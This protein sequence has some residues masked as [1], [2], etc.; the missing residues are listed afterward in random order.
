MK[1]SKVKHTKF[2]VGI[3]GNAD[4]TK[5]FIY[6][7]PFESKN[8]GLTL[9]KR[10]ENLNK[11]AKNLY[12]IL[13]PHITYTEDKNVI[14]T[15]KD[16][17]HSIN[18]LITFLL[19]IYD[20]KSD[21]RIQLQKK[22]LTSLTPD[23]VLITK[24]N[25]KKNGYEDITM[26]QLYVD[27]HSYGNGQNGKEAV[28]NDLVENCLRK[29]LRKDISIEPGKDPVSI[30]ETVKKIINAATCPNNFQEKLKNTVTD[31]ELTAFF[32]IINKDYDK[33]KRIEQISESIEWQNVKVQ[34][35]LTEYG[36]V[37][38]LSSALEKNTERQKE[39]YKKYIF[40]FITDYTKSDT[41]RKK[42][43]IVHMRQLILLFCTVFYAEDG[44]PDFEKN[45][46]TLDYVK[47][48]KRFETFTEN[49]PEYFCKEAH[50]AMDEISAIK[51]SS[52]KPDGNVYTE[53]K[54]RKKKLQNQV[55][56]SIRT[57]IRCNYSACKILT[58]EH[59]FFDHTQYQPE[60]D[61]CWLNYISSTV[62]K[63][64]VKNR[65]WKY[66]SV[67]LLCRTVFDEWTAYIA[68]KYIHIGKAVYHFA[69]PDLTQ[70]ASQKDVK[71]GEIQ[72]P[73]SEG[74]TSFDYEWI[75]AKETLE[76]DQIVSVTFAVQNY[77]RCICDSRK[78]KD[79][80]EN[81]ED[82][83]LFREEDFKNVLK[84]EHEKQE[85][86]RKM[87]QYF[88]GISKWSNE[89]DGKYSKDNGSFA[90]DFAQAVKNEMF[91][92]RNSCYHYTAII[93]E[94]A[95]KESLMQKM[96][97]IEYRKLGEFLFEKYYSNNVFAFYRTAEI[98]CMMEYLYDRKSSTPSQVPAFNRII[99]GKQEDKD[100][101]VWIS[102]CIGSESWKDGFSDLETRKVYKASFRFLLKE[103]Y[104]HGFLN[105]PGIKKKFLKEIDKR[106]KNGKNWKEEKAAKNLQQRLFSLEKGSKKLSFG[107]I[108]QAIM[109]DYNMQNQGHMK[110]KVKAGPD[111]EN[112][113]DQEIFQHFRMLLYAGI[114]S[115]FSDYLMDKENPGTFGFLKHPKARSME[116]KKSVFDRFTGNGENP[117]NPTL[118]SDVYDA[119]S[120]ETDCQNQ[121]GPELLAWYTTAH[122]MN[123]KQLNLLAGSIKNYIQFSCDIQK[124]EKSA[125]IKNPRIYDTK[126][127]NRYKKVIRVLEF[128]RLFVGQT[129][130]ILEDYFENN[131]DYARHVANYVQLD[132]PTVE[133]LQAFCEQKWR[134]ENTSGNQDDRIGIYFD[135]V[136]P[137]IN[138]NIVYA[139]MYGMEQILKN[140]VEPVEKEEILKLY[141]LRESLQNVF[142]NGK[143]ETKKEQ[144]QLRDFTNC[145]NRI[146][147]V[148]I[149][150]YS[151]M[152]NELF[153]QLVSWA[154]L[155]ERDLMYFQLGYH[156][157]RLF[158]GKK[159]PA[160]D[161]MRTLKGKR[162]DI[163][164]GAILY[165]I[166]AMY[167][168]I[169]PVYKI[170]KE[171]AVIG[172]KNVSTGASISAFCK[173]CGEDDIYNAG[174]FFFEI[175]DEHDFISAFRNEIDHFKYF[176]HA[177]R[178][179]L[180][181]YSMIYDR[182]FDYDL[183]LKK[184][185][186]Y[187]FKNILARY[188]VVAD[189]TMFG[190]PGTACHKEIKISKDRSEYI[191]RNCTCMKIGK[192][193]LISDLLV[194][195]IDGHDV[196]ID[197]CDR[198]FLKEVRNILEYKISE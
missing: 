196:K 102:K 1:V 183:K 130:N 78:R 140:C 71:I 12:R 66:N 126:K 29:S 16:I 185:M 120:V 81:K 89:E 135:A 60:K 186:T 159:D 191:F 163:S 53:Q 125:N 151:E 190:N 97:A 55:M 118:F 116:Q 179:I 195:K 192:G 172:A 22:N 95:K 143:C 54:R 68:Q 61:L 14:Q 28:I 3:Q 44:M 76:R 36:T 148:N 57:Q 37:L 111:K 161:W 26:G 164:D 83:L 171:K 35:A 122:F 112:P 50:D 177:D 69:M 98:R 109:T 2:A 110:V 134:K 188:F 79:F 10:I 67:E 27:F 75:K 33:E 132:T 128:T 73:F 4:T 65:K 176:T 194:F 47:S 198:Q 117:W 108:C 25:R 94:N 138:R 52:H 49:I 82:I 189:T 88:G 157:I 107:E 84:G 5:G 87:L 86:I 160:D 169:L 20:K 153:G 114:R 158:C 167:A 168:Y 43:M 48:D 173:Y 100:I 72:E 39:N 93:S 150:T 59:G 23:S 13:T 166:V 123:P 80:G 146:E 147:L 19:K 101:D 154:Y 144:V 77:S 137:I 184:S 105:E 136:N 96:F 7:N 178:S 139:S 187:I 127:I 91:L 197:A 92:L 45:K 181:Y 58:K 129:S 85:A 104:Y 9:N 62:E 24:W 124:R 42:T 182:F 11:S 141:Q 156:Y 99:G 63:L 70:L 34:P 119:I 152:V 41:D 113:Y 51:D 142:Q 40:Q 31:Q 162:I 170:E 145:K 21:I 32:S 133:G 46:K 38:Q 174:L 193:G 165:Q 6:D 30:K 18:N 155:R 121:D 64:L 149:T 8:S 56:E 106:T 103:I 131:E 115:A 180:E 175:L 15:C 17:N 90:V 74:L